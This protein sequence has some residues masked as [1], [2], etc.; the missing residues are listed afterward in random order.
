M[1]ETHPDT[2]DDIKA[3]I[4]ESVAEGRDIHARVRDLT[5]QSLRHRRFNAEETE[6]V[7]RE[8]AAGIGMGLDRRTGEVKAALSEAAAGLDEAL[9]KLAEASHLA[10]R[11]LLANSKDFT[12]HELK[13][14]VGNLQRLEE[15][16]LSTLGQAAE[17]AGGTARRE[18]KDLVTHARRAGTDT[19]AKV[20]ATAAE[21]GDRMRATL[22]GGKAAGKAAAFEVSA[23]FATLAS[24]ILAGLADALRDK[25][26]KGK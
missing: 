7:I 15:D 20:A 17:A 2:P 16:F 12:E 4:A 10:L 3:A 24:G 26:G 11:Q 13:Q 9:A 19:G 23:R 25:S 5:L 14:T 21:F 18:M 6:S 22:Q 8:V 1:S